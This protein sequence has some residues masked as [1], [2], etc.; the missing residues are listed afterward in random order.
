MIVTLDAMARTFAG[1]GA[2]LLLGGAVVTGLAL[3]A[4]RL[5]FARDAG[6]RCAIWGTAIALGLAAPAVLGRVDLRGADDASVVHLHV[7]LE[8]EVDG[9]GTRRRVVRESSPTA[10][11]RGGPSGA[12][13]VV[14]WPVDDPVGPRAILAIAAIWAAFGTARLIRRFRLLLRDRREALPAGAALTSRVRS[15]A[16]R[17]G[18]TRR[19]GVAVVD[20]V[21]SPRLVLG[22]RPILLLPRALA[23]APRDELDAILLHELAH[24]ARYDDV[25]CLVVEI[26]R[27]LLPF[28]LPLR[29]AA[30]R[31]DDEREIACDD[32]AAR[33]LG[34]G[35]PLARALT[36][37]ARPVALRHA[38]APH[39]TTTPGRLARRV[40]RLARL[41]FVTG[42]GAAAR[43]GVTLLFVVASLGALGSIPGVEFAP[44]DGRAAATDRHVLRY[45]L[46]DPGVRIAIEGGW[47]GVGAALRGG[48]SIDD[49]SG[50]APWRL[51]LRA[52]PG[53]GIARRV[54]DDGTVVPL[55]LAERRRLDRVLAAVAADVRTTPS[56]GRFLAGLAAWGLEPPPA[57]PSD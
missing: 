29:L 3:L 50:E 7:D 10:A 43:R 8:D 1:L 49:R 33:A 37:A 54:V 14:E 39:A 46:E 25:Q 6:A 17:A 2:S 55:G 16:R 19:V 45:A 42:G 36:A 34:S 21:G 41:E 28:D 38:P 48:L 15:L 27:A 56:G 53:E 30:R 35:R 23:D 40:R 4:T 52:V 22:G 31:L 9:V 12:P 57:P 18:V 51:E 24:A 32:F 5:P 44:A 13:R 20:R 11:T 47:F 26:L